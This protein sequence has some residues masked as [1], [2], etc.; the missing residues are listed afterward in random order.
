MLL[1]QETSLRPDIKLGH[2]ESR[3]SSASPLP[4]TIHPAL[5]GADYPLPPSTSV[6]LDY[7]SGLICR[8][9]LSL[10]QP[11]PS[12]PILDVGG[13]G[14]ILDRLEAVGGEIRDQS[15]LTQ[16]AVGCD[17]DPPECP[18]TEDI[19][20]QVCDFMCFLKMKTLYRVLLEW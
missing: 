20:Q 18:P 11:H 3:A 5:R 16:V 12:A 2:V 6:A 13:A 7:T 1:P 4:P 17:Q 8:F 19:L 15:H 10:L 9:S 14:G